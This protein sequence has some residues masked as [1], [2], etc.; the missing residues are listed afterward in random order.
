MTNEKLMLT[1]LEKFQRQEKRRATFKR[2]MMIF[3]DSLALVS[4][5]G[6]LYGLLLIGHAFGLS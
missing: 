4:M 2:Y 6:M 1:G 5:F 3:L